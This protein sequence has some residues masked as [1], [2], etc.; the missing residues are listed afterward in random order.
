MQGHSLYAW[1]KS[2]GL[3]TFTLKT[4]YPHAIPSPTFGENAVLFLMLVGDIAPPNESNVHSL[5]DG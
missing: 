4:Y 5:Q 1:D 3:L 2:L